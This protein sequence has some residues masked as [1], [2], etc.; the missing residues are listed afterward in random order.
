MKRALAVLV[1]FIL[2]VGFIPGQALALLTN[3]SSASVVQHGMNDGACALQ[4]SGLSVLSDEPS[5]GQEGPSVPIAKPEAVTGA[6]PPADEATRE[7]VYVKDY[8]NRDYAHYYG[9]AADAHIDDGTVIEAALA[10]AGGKTLVFEEGKTYT[11]GS[12]VHSN[13]GG[14]LW[15]LQGIRTS[16]SD[17]VIEGNGATI[18]WD[19]SQAFVGGEGLYLE[20]TKDAPVRDIVIRNL[21]FSAVNSSRTFED[22]ITGKVY[23]HHNLV[24]LKGMWCENVLIENCTFEAVPNSDDSLRELSNKEGRGVSNIWFYGGAKDVTVRDCTMRNVTC[25]SQESGSNLLFS[26]DCE[27]LRSSSDD[28]KSAYGAMTH[29]EQY[30]VICERHLQ[31]SVENILV[32]GNRFEH[33]CHDECISLWSA[34]LFKDVL[35]QENSFDIH[36]GDAHVP[37]TTR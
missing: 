9:P 30:R 36:D 29:D 8:Y 4:A 27:W 17:V 19:A 32:E 20:G 15:R 28:F 13:T 24:Q 3:G 18:R 21:N 6:T 31:G 34:E 25:G 33:A 10:E 12:Y 7:K 11:F 23:E 26:G 1:S 2:V 37:S 5:S 22:P 14:N 35:I 16:T